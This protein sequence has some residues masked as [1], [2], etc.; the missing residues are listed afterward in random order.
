G[1]GDGCLTGRDATKLFVMS[2]SPRSKLKQVVASSK[3]ILLV[4]E[5]GRRYIISLKREICNCGRFQLDKICTHNCYFEEQE[6]HRSASQL[7]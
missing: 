3:F 4:Y 1:D 2:N 6:Y 5:S 7:L